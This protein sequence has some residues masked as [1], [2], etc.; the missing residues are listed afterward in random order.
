MVNS[1]NCFQKKGQRSVTHFLTD[2]GS[3]HKPAAITIRS[4]MK[5][6]SSVEFT[7]FSNFKWNDNNYSTEWGMRSILYAIYDPPSMCTSC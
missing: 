2:N 6:D 7:Q 1:Q 3:L 5:R 4:L